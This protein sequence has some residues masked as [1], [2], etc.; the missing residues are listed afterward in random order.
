VQAFFKASTFTVVGNRQQALFWEDLWI[1]GEAAS[2]IGPSL[3][4]LVPARI[5]SRQSVQTGLHKRTLACNI[6]GGMSTQ[7]I[8]DYFHLWNTVTEIQL[9]NQPDRTMVSFIGRNLLI[10]PIY[11]FY[12]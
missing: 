9:S 1:N 3:Y 11:P 8:I 4:P 5:R 6:T 2:D 12:P 10:F 7:A